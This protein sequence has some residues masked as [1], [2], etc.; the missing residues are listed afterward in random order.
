MQKFYSSERGSALPTYVICVGLIAIFAVAG[1]AAS[2]EKVSTIFGNTVTAINETTGEENTP[3]PVNRAPVILTTDITPGLSGE[4]YTFAMAAHD[5]DGDTLSWTASDLPD[6]LSI[7]GNG[8]ITGTPSAEGQFNPVFSVSDG[9]GGEDQRELEMTVAWGGP[10]D[11]QGTQTFTSSHSGPW[12]TLPSDPTYRDMWQMPEGCTRLVIEV[13]GGGGMGYGDERIPGAG[14]WALVEYHKVAPSQT[15]YIVA[16]TYPWRDNTRRYHGGLSGVFLGSSMNRADALVVVGGGG[17]VGGGNSTA[18]GG[19]GGG[20]N[21]NGQH[22][23]RNGTAA[24]RGATVSAP[25]PSYA[26]GSN[27]GIDFVGGDASSDTLG[28]GGGNGWY[29]GSS[30][31]TGTGGGGGGGS[32]YA[33]LSRVNVLGSTTGGGA[34]A[35]GHYTEVADEGNGW[36]TLTWE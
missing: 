30:G 8:D 24:G 6:G 32:G 27:P 12:S 18:H 36:V 23:L 20:A 13:A 19:D 10:C 3:Q 35:A 11:N 2:G 21:Q 16:G 17:S 14:G 9:K 28:G 5:E 33:D 29:G 34:A 15:F 1:I 26:S 31:A 4:A 7:D 25:G 22:G